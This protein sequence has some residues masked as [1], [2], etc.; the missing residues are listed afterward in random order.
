ML[1]QLKKRDILFAVICGEISSW[2]LIFV[3]K[4]PYI[5]ELKGLTGIENLIWLLPLIF[6]LIFLLGIITA[7]LLG[8]LIK[9]FHQIIIF[10]EVGILNTMIDFGILN[11]LIW[12]TG[13]TGGWN[14][15]PLNAISFLFA[16]TNSYFW[17]KFWTFKTKKEASGKEFSQFLIISVIGMGVNTGIVVAGTSLISPLAGLSL[18]AWANIIKLAATIFS[19]IWN[20]IGYKF[21][22]FKK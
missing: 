14:L 13:I 15:A 11:L 4:N 22:V 12:L 21:I 16:T 17:N 6:P 2:F 1:S 8:R 18:G 3:I 10:A 19:M 5:E 20:F 7:E 9:V